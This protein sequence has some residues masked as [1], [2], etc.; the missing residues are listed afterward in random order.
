MNWVQLKSCLC[1]DD[2][3]K[4]EVKTIPASLEQSIITT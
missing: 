4:V 3:I 2:K 1:S